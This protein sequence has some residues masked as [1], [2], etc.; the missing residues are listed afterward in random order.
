[1]NMLPQFNQYLYTHK[2]SSDTKFIFPLTG[3]KVTHPLQIGKCYIVPIEKLDSSIKLPKIMT[4]N[5]FCVS[6]TTVDVSNNWKKESDNYSIALQL[7][8]QSIGALY[9]SIY[10][11]K[12]RCDDN[13]RIVISNIGSHE[14]DEGL[15][16]CKS[17]NQLKNHIDISSIL[18]F[19]DRDLNKLCLENIEVIQSKMNDYYSCDCEYG[20]KILKSLEITYCINNE[21][22]ANERILKICAVINL[23]FRKDN[24]TEKDSHYFASQLQQLFNYFSVKIKEKIPKE[25]INEKLQGT[26]YYDIFMG[27]YR[28]IRNNF[29]HG[30]INLYKEFTMINTTDYL[31]FNVSLMELLNILIKRSEFNELKTTEELIDK[32]MIN[33]KNYKNK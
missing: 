8:K 33:N 11:S 19:T 31:L 5:I 32:I 20:N 1:M 2:P 23:L 30:K 28:N 21:I 4:S 6:I 22:Y 24:E 26:K 16:V 10:N 18:F 9:L 7:T 3:I 13:R 27:V 17:E 12:E 29:I 25:F 15:V 14:L